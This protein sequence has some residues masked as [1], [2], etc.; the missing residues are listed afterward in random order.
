MGL[1]ETEELSKEVK[2]VIKILRDNQNNK[3][4]PNTVGF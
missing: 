1:E 2:K 3:L 4:D